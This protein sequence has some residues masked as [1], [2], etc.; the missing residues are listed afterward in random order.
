MLDS[1]GQTG[2]KL[3]AFLLLVSLSFASCQALKR[4]GGGGEIDEANQLNRSAGEDIREI[5]KIIQEN[6]TKESE[7]SRAL[8]A[9]QIDAAK[10]MMDD[11]VKAIER[12]LEKGESA[13]AKF[14]KAA[15]LDVDPI[16]K[17][18]LSL[19]AQSVNR[20]IEAF[21]ELRRGIIVF[22]DAT[23]S[24]DKAATEKARAEIRQAS[25]KF[26][27]LISETER[28]ELQA[29]EIAR[30]HPDKIKPGQ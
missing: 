17:E 19:R 16:I 24:T 15:K 20:A 25:E 7:V 12:G 10:R 29:D 14:D 8:N 6:K 22:R 26:D 5:E 3:T 27:K 9:G 28:L 23:G 11:S 30:R 18:Y 2:A 21:S 1:R 13:A 4:L